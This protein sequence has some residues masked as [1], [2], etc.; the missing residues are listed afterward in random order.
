M[1]TLSE[2]FRRHN[3]CSIRNMH[4]TW[5]LLLCATVF[6]MSIASNQVHGYL[7]DGRSLQKMMAVQRRWAQRPAKLE[8]FSKFVPASKKS[9]GYGVLSK[10]GGS[11]AR[12]CYFTPVSCMIQHD[13][14]KYKKLIESSRL[15][16]FAN[17]R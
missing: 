3:Q 14:S 2:D 13:M 7:I 5:L 15:D 11:G 17:L 10:F 1:A 6:F 8:E 16:V 4:R 9:A 12:N